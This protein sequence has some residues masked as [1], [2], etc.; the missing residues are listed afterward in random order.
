MP[1]PGLCRSIAILVRL[2][3]AMMATCKQGSCGCTGATRNGNRNRFLVM[4]GE[5]RTFEDAVPPTSAGIEND[6]E[7]ERATG[8]VEAAEIHEPRGHIPDPA[9]EMLVIGMVKEIV[10]PQAQLRELDG[11]PGH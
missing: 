9:A 7:P 11:F 4:S 1:A 3:L 5:R 8:L 6:P 2:I 10:N